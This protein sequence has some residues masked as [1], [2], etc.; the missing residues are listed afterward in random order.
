MT[1]NIF[2]WLKKQTVTNIKIHFQSCL[3][4]RLNKYNPP[5]KNGN[6]IFQTLSPSWNMWRAVF[7]K[8]NKT[9]IYTLY[10]SL[11]SIS[12]AIYWWHYLIATSLF[13]YINGHCFKF[14][15]S[16]KI[17]RQA[18]PSSISMRFSQGSISE[19]LMKKKSKLTKLFNI[20]WKWLHSPIEYKKY[21][22]STN[23]E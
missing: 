17:C 16:H 11:I 5:L 8:Y 10:F 19:S 23:V 15:T 18:C 4:F 22:V 9:L 7:W 14:A 6:I 12:N 1:Y 20:C 3:Q 21:M 13:Y 2:R